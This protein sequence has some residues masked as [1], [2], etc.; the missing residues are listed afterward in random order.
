MPHTKVG[1]MSSDTVLTG[2]LSLGSFELCGTED[3]SSLGMGM[4]R[5]HLRG[6]KALMG[7]IPGEV[8]AH[9]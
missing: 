1:L 2:I 7:E 5:F 3:L 8:K 6:T 9:T 4:L